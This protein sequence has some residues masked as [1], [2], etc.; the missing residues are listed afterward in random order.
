MEQE[1]LL[2]EKEERKKIKEEKKQLKAEQKLQRKEAKKRARELDDQ[3]AEL[4]DD[5]GGGLTVIIFT[6][7]IILIWFFILG[8]L[9][10]LD[11]GGFGSNVLKPI[12]KDVPVIQYILPNSSVNE[13]V[14]E[15]ETGMSIQSLS[16]AL[17]QIKVLQ[18]QLEQSA[19]DV[20]VLNEQNET[21]EKE[22]ERLKTFEESQIEFE[23]IRTQFYDEVI[24][25]ENG[26]G[27]ESYVTYFES[28]NPE[29]AENL[30]KQ[31]IRQL[32]ESEEIKTYAQ[33]YSEMKAKQAAAIFEEMTDNLELVS[34]ILG[35][36]SVENRGSI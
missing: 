10:K 24:Y 5:G 1:N 4:L 31:V 6:L 15:N 34:R 30:Y 16:E 26:P 8:V 33:T 28:M 18:L 32:E 9:I 12:L 17:E 11:V 14:V 23:R 22:I 21:L 25:A 3:E 29:T 20:S 27:A 7:I 19:L 13:G 35:A 2:D 36:M